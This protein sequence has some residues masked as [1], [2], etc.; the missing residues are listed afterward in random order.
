MAFC[1]IEV[2]C[3]PSPFSLSVRMIVE[4]LHYVLPSCCPMN[5]SCVGFIHQ[6]KENV[7]IKVPVSLFSH[8]TEH[9]V[10]GGFLGLEHWCKSGL[11][12][13]I[14][15]QMRIRSLEKWNSDYEVE[16][17][18]SSLISVSSW[19][20]V[21]ILTWAMAEVTSCS[22]T[23]RATV[24]SEGSGLLAWKNLKTQVPG[25]TAMF[26]SNLAQWKWINKLKWFALNLYHLCYK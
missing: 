4:K 15:T 21:I 11:L 17:C 6:G 3:F 25:A 8:S 7:V 18:D 16:C 20:H 26:V 1:K 22:K 5:D 10:K 24:L 14:E 23:W 2:F 19:L 13:T 9:M 12:L